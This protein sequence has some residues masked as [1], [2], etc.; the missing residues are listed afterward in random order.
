MEAPRLCWRSSSLAHQEVAKELSS[1]QAAACTRGAAAGGSPPAADAPPTTS[2]DGDSGSAATS[3]GVQVSVGAQLGDSTRVGVKPQLGGLAGGAA[4][5]TMVA[6]RR[7]TAAKG[8]SAGL[9]P[10]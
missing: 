2:T 5:G 3:V 4:V 9:E 1:P 7:S 6:Q 8:E 10:K